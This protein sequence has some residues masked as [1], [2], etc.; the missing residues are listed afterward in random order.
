MRIVERPS[1]AGLTTLGLGGTCTRLI[2]IENEAELAGLGTL[3][4]RG[5][6][7]M[8]F[9]MGSNILAMDGHHDV[10]LVRCAQ[11]GE[12]QVAG[13]DKDVVTIRCQAG[14][15]LQALLARC[16]SEGWSGIEGLAGI[17]GSV[18]GA[19]A[20]NAGSFGSVIG[21]NVVSVDV[22]A[23]GQL[24]TFTRADMELGYR[25]FRPRG[26]GDAFYLVTGCVLRFNRDEPG[27]VA[28]RMRATLA[29]KKAR[30]PLGVRSA[31]C[32]FKN[33]AD[34]HS[35][36]L[37]LDRAGYR[38]RRHGGVELSSIHANFL[39]NTGQGSAAQA[40]ELLAEARDAVARSQ[41]VTL[42]LEVRGIPCLCL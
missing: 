29:L 28:E 6:A 41:G 38:G 16:R 31:G 25:V 26:L 19:V 5:P 12:V 27:A 22:W 36:G 3:L 17:P 33:P 8:A 34:G 11:R 18:G 9:G 4:A 32:V 14:L 39:V 24:Q 13:R 35:A 2:E 15:P 7:P 10:T 21:D 42:E 23:D 37:L 40:R 1:L 20:M 30:Q